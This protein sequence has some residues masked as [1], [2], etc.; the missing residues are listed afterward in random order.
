[1]NMNMP[2]RNY[3]GPKTDHINVFEETN[4]DG[5]PDR[6]WTFAEGFKDARNGW[7]SIPCQGCRASLRRRTLSERTIV[8]SVLF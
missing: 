4:G 1:M 7:F 8:L 3:P 5:K 2:P 6:I